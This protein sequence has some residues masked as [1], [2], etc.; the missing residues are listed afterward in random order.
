MR[1]FMLVVSL[2]MGFASTSY[3]SL[4]DLGNGIIYDSEQDISWSKDINPL[5]TAC[6]AAAG[7]GKEMWDAFSSI[8]ASMNSS[9]SSGRTPEQIC[10]VG[11]GGRLNKYEALLWVV[12]LD[13]HEYLGYSG[14]RMPVADTACGAALDCDERKE[15]ELGHL[16]YTAAPDGLGNQNMIAGCGNN[17]PGGCFI[18]KGPFS[19]T[20]TEHSYWTQTSAPPES[21]QGVTIN[22]T[23]VFHMGTGVQSPDP[24]HGSHFGVWPVRYG[25]LPLPSTGGGDCNNDGNVDINDVICTINK[26]LAGP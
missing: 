2:L 14:W 12:I 5:L 22:R 25:L 23:W 3:A 9:F 15:S 4:H 16:H 17:I 7:K 24:N 1:K 26:V 18:E 10:T 8:H 20:G 6:N 11:G 19:Y 13:V 21:V